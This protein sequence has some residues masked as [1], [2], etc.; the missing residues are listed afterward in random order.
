MFAHEMCA[1][2]QW[3]STDGLD[4]H[5]ISVDSADVV[6]LSMSS[7]HLLDVPTLHIF[8]AYMDTEPHV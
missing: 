2:L 7:V 8:V 1:T 6:G 3:L 5:S 4:L